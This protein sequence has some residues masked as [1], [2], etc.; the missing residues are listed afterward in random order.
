M[1]KVIDWMERHPT[2]VAYATMGI[3]LGT[4]LALMWALR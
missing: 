1:N 3:I 2:V 4:G